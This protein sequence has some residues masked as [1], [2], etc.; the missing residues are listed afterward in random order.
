VTKQYT[1]EGPEGKQSLPEL[2]DGRSQLVVYHFMFE[3]EWD[4]G[5]KHCSFWADNFN[6]IV[7]HVNHRDAT[8]IAVS[9][10]PHAKLDRYKKRMGWSFKWVSSF[11]SDFN[12]D[13]G[14]SF[15]PEQLA[16]QEA[17][18]NYGTQNPGHAEREGASVFY[19]DATGKV[20][21]TYSTYGRGIDMLN[22]AYHYIDLTPQGRDEGD[23]PQRWVRRHDEYER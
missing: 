15:A 20:F 8:F 16:S 18:Y 17:L 23:T 22:T 4:A 11:G 5:C 1:F 10:A 2:F 3:P 7:V 13:Y 19:Q 6:G 9:R 21:H 12:F 14:V